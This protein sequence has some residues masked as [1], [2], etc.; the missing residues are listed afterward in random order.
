MHARGG[1]DPAAVPVAAEHVRRAVAGTVVG[2]S[3]LQPRPRELEPLA[4]YR[5]PAL[6]GCGGLSFA[7]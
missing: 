1:S 6:D 7:P 3:W 5:M 4:S 2:D